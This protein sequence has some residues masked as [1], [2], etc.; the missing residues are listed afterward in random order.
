[1]AV[2]RQRR[3]R[4]AVGLCTAAA[5]LLSAHAIAGEA[6]SIRTGQ[7]EGFARLVFEW[8]QGIGVVR[9]ARDGA[10]VLRF[11]RSMEAD[12]EA[13]RAE[14]APYVEAISSGDDPH[15]IWLRPLAGVGV[16]VWTSGDRK[17]VVDL[18]SRPDQ[19]PRVAVRLGRHQGYERMVL[20]WPVPVSF[21]V[22]QVHPRLR[23]E[24]DRSLAVDPELLRQHLP[25][26]ALDVAG[27]IDGERGWLELALAAATVAEVSSQGYAD[28]IVIDLR[29]TAIPMPSSKAEALAEA[30]SR[31]PP[32]PR[33]KP[34]RAI[35]GNAEVVILP[36]RADRQLAESWPQHASTDGQAPWH[37]LWS[38]L[39]WSFRAFASMLEGAIGWYGQ[40]AIVASSAAARRD[41]L[42][43]QR[44][45]E[46]SSA[47]VAG[48]ALRRSGSA[49]AG[50]EAAPGRADS[51]LPAAPFR[52]G[53]SVPVSTRPALAEFDRPRRLSAPASGDRRAAD[54][55]LQAEALDAVVA[56]AMQT[57]P[58][59]PVPVPGSRAPG[60]SSTSD[61]PEDNPE[62][63]ALNRVLVEAG[64][65]LLPAWGVE[66]APETMYQYQGSSGLL[67]VEQ[68][69]GRRTAVG[70][71][72]RR[73]TIEAATTLR[74]GLPWD[75]QVEVR[76][77]YVYS[78]EELSVGGQ[79]ENSRNS[80][81]LGDVEL[82]L[83][84]QLLHE[85]KWYPDLLG[86]FRWKSN[87][88]KDNFDAGS[89]GLAT[90]TGFHGLGGAL[91]AVKSY[92][93]MVFFGRLAYTANLKDE[94]DGFDIDPGDTFSVGMGAILSAGPGTSFRFGI[95]QSF[96]GEVAV[97][98]D[99]IAGTD[100]V[101]G[102]LQIG[103][104]AALPNRA[105][106]DI[107][108]GVG[109]TDDAPDFVVRAALP[110]R[111]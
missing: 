71:Q 107:S 87:T 63:E 47:L 59:L 105:L 6:V 78:D 39:I 96:T 3:L 40:P 30:A 7:H 5:A 46:A 104:S 35:D 43:E 67:V 97:D 79:E 74:L 48:G 88:G 110:Y 76:I 8:P 98:G 111:F 73:D 102:V 77:P 72:A 65:L 16:Q 89:D 69:D 106:L 86:E 44:D 28:R 91:T 27:G 94:K 61:D 33:F 29:S 51:V 19:N 32:T 31:L 42:L 109:I 25:G 52:Q 12:L 24:F 10:V 55:E 14:L 100:E 85:S 80:S 45:E 53:D 13:A 1:M 11:D 70:Q 26:T 34:T 50:P 99:K 81:G 9:D 36:W 62:L 20:Q 83:S 101:S 82:G 37:P 4:L 75:S 68:E 38:W 57:E 49:L 23:I 15:E 58:D 18:R 22:T 90:G 64:G 108:A 103:A 41:A 21:A 92:D 54:G 2:L 66:L 84:H 17:V 60:D 93:P 95:S 56:G